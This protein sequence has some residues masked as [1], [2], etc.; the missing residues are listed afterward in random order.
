MGTFRARACCCSS[1]VRRPR[2]QGSIREM[3][4][5]YVQ[6]RLCACALFIEDVFFPVEKCGRSIEDMCAVERQ[7]WSDRLE[8]RT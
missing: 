2:L 5:A 3:E 6:G 1:V 7:L 8:L 4:S